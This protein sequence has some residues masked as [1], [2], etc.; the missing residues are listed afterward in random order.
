[1][2]WGYNYLLSSYYYKIGLTK[3][4]QNNAYS[5]S[6]DDITDIRNGKCHTKVIK[7]NHSRQAKRNDVIG[8]FIYDV[9]DYLVRHWSYVEKR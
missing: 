6:F 3:H 9:T 7:G 4:R 1:M 8:R 5:T 2:F